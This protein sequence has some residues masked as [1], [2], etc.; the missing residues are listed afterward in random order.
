MIAG[1]YFDGTSS[2][3][4]P[5]TVEAVGTALH[6]VG[7]DLDRTV[8]PPDL[9]FSPSTD[10]GPARIVFADGAL[11]EFDDRA[12]AAA[13]FTQLGHR[14]AATDR[15]VSNT[16][17]VLTVTVAFIA[18]MAALYQ[19]GIPWVSDRLVEHAPQRW[20]DRMGDGIL[21]TLDTRH[22]F[23]PTTLPEP[24]RSRVF[25]RFRTLKRLPGAPDAQIVFR[26]L[27]SPNALALPG[28]M[29]VV[30][31]ELVVLAGGDDDALATVLAHEI[32]HVA[33]RDALRQ[34]A[35]STITSA[36][37]AW[38]LGDVSSTAAIAAGSIGTLTYSRDAEHEADLYA[39]ETMRANGISTKPAAA[40][41]RRLEAWEPLRRR[42]ADEV[43]ADDGRKTATKRPRLHI[44]EYLST[45]P[46]TDGRIALFERDGAAE[47]KTP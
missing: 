20:D 17:R 30:S 44:P 29:I 28:G 23:R 14:P 31:D 34:L 47:P 35:R 8:E 1:R 19:W 22:F 6:V 40:L 42:P 45:H 33:H 4:W 9:S 36:L 41:F 3:P 24:V 12:A 25:E 38:Y 46:D 21:Q 43:L 13:L 39:V 32:G 18:V 27:G 7:D 10:R 37:A 2:R 26:K 15:L 11:C 5:V 16:R